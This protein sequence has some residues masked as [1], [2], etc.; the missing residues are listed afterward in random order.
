MFPSDLQFRLRRDYRRCG[1]VSRVAARQRGGVAAKRRQDNLTSRRGGSRRPSA[2]IISV[3]LVGRKSIFDSF[4][5][6]AEGTSLHPIWHRCRTSLS[7]TRDKQCCI[8]KTLPSCTAFVVRGCTRLSAVPKISLGSLFPTLNQ[9][10]GV[11]FHF[12]ASAPAFHISRSSQ[13]AQTRD[14][15]RY[16]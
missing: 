9:E 7:S 15:I 12:I 3:R 13:K 6:W 8:Q 4:F 16:V 5:F 10:V 14:C 1:A 11:S 2:S